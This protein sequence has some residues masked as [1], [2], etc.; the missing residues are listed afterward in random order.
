MKKRDLSASERVDLV[1]SI[2]PGDRVT[3]L[4]PNGIGRD[5]I[6][7]KEATGRCK[8]KFSTHA[9]LNMGGP[10]GRPGVADEKNIVRVRRAS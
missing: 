3:I 5:G 6:E 10:Y 9:V 1:A 8:L 2:R 4:V 7:W